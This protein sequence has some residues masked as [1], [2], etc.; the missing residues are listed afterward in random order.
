[1]IL[2]DRLVCLPVSSSSCWQQ[3]EHTDVERPRVKLKMCRTWLVSIRA[4]VY[5]RASCCD[6]CGNKPF[7]AS[8][9]IYGSAVSSLSG[10]L[11]TH[12]WSSYI[13]SPPIGLCWQTRRFF[14]DSIE[15]SLTS[16][17]TP[18]RHSI[19]VRQWLSGGVPDLQSGGCRFE[20]RPGLRRTKVY[21][22]FHPSG[23]GK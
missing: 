8:Y 15:Q 10:H 7:P 17:S 12:R 9:E 22:V 4:A 2:K 14:C 5:S 21:S 11:P 16:H 23:V 18:T 6:W 13:L 1:M 20:S 3:I 19:L